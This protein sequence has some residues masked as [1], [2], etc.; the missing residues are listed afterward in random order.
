MGAATVLY[1]GTVSDTAAI[2]TAVSTNAA[3]T[4]IIV[5]GAN[6]QQVTIY[7]QGS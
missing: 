4:L 7:L 3:T 6:G 2:I 5:P 1:N